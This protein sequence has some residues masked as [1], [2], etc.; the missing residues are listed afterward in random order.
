MKYRHCKKIM[1]YFCDD[2]IAS[3]TARTL[4]INRNA[5]NTYFNE[6][7]IKIPENSIK[8]HSKEFGIFEVDESPFGAR[9]IL[10]KKR[11]RSRWRSPRFWLT[12]FI[13]AIQNCF[14]KVP[15]PAISRKMLE[16]STIYTDGWSAHDWL[17]FTTAC[18][19]VRT[20][21][22]LAKVMQTASNFGVL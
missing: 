2:L 8:E 17:I 3:T 18:T 4:S 19:T 22:H 7:R 10:E 9:R 5:I 20:N 16:G 1:R 12:K 14:K 21:S 13:R 11:A 15:M 6:F